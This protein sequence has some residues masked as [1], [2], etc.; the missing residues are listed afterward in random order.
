MISL[1]FPGNK[2]PEHTFIEPL[3]KVRNLARCPTDTVNTLGIHAV[4]LNRLA[5]LLYDRW[6]FNVIPSHLLCQID[7]KSWSALV[8]YPI[9]AIYLYDRRRRLFPVMWR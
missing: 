4:F 5:T 6:N 7:S 2:E 3:S 1:T 9:T 8:L